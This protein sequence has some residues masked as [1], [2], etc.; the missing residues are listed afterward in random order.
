MHTASPAGAFP[1]KAAVVYTNGTYRGRT[2]ATKRAR[3]FWSGRS[4][5]IRLPKEFRFEGEMVLVHRKGRAVILEPA[6]EW[7]EDYVESFAGI[8][9]DFVRPPQGESE[10]RGKLA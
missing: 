10:K 7:P 6:D 3:V 9:S 2:M 1:R 5:A 8:G 4:Q